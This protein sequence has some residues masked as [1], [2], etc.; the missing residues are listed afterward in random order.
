MH[1]TEA[2]NM[3]CSYCYVPEKI[4]SLP[5]MDKFLAHSI[6]N[7]LLEYRDKHWKN[8]TVNVIFHG[9]EPMLN[10]ELLYEIVEEWRDEKIT[11]GVQ[12]NGTL[13]NEEDIM[14]FK[15][16]NIDVGIS[17]DGPSSRY[18]DIQR[19][20]I[21]GIG[22]FKRVDEVLKMFKSYKT[23]VGAIVTVTKHNVNALRDMLRYLL[24]HEVE[25][26]LFNPVSPSVP[27]A[28][29]LTPSIE[30]LIT[31]YRYLSYDLVNMNQLES[32]LTIKNIESLIIALITTNMRV[33]A[34]DAS[35]CGAARLLLVVTSEGD[36][37]PCS[38]FVAF[39][40]FRLGNILKH[41]I[42]DLL[43]RGPAIKLRSRRVEEITDCCSC[44]YGLICGAN[45][46]ASVYSLHR[47]L[48]NLH[49][50]ANLK[51]LY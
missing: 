5:K 17:I 49:I 47:D 10:K 3:S 50:I 21:N 34:C 13:I 40:E 48:K 8:V 31:S 24:S 6:I 32:R 28:Y 1:L 15:K 38:E 41:S 12:T 4:R 44:P 43:M 20:Y 37:F 42:E 18:H 23:P 51:W 11:F 30:A 39:P 35:P 27:N 16:H 7:K 45:C 2:C 46:P 36:V 22:T 26:A 14:F 19:F 25:S 33:L 29:K 9:G